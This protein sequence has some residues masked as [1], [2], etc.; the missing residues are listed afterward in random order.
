[1]LV[2]FC[3]NFTNRGGVISLFVCQLKLDKRT[4]SI[5]LGCKFRGSAMPVR[6]ERAYIGKGS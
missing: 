2:G 5:S 6:R 3:A 1:M 4:I